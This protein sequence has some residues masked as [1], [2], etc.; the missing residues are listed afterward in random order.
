VSL[1]H[2]TNAKQIDAT[3]AALPH[4][5]AGKKCDYKRIKQAVEPRPSSLFTVH[6]SSIL[7]PLDVCPWH[8]KSS[9]CA[10]LKVLVWPVATELVE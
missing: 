5:I 7:H 3:L 10:C 9:F 1:R 2:A 6:P 4:E 8:A